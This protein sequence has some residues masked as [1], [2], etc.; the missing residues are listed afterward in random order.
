MNQPSSPASDN[1]HRGPWTQHYVYVPEPYYL[2]LD[3]EGHPV[4]RVIDDAALSSLILVAPILKA[5]I[6]KAVDLLRFAQDHHDVMGAYHVLEDVLTL[7]DSITATMKDEP[8]QMMTMIKTRSN[9]KSTAKV[10]QSPP[11]PLPEGV[12]TENMMFVPQVATIMNFGGGTAKVIAGKTVTDEKGGVLIGTAVDGRSFIHCP[13][14][15]AV[16]LPT[17]KP[18]EWDSPEGPAATLD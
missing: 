3:N 1:P 17:G 10:M 4:A 13:N 12:I 11:E 5:E 7:D 8:P 18:F 9:G 2:I 15:G 14:C 16:D 6:E